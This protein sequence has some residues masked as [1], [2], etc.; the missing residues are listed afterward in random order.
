M[1]ELTREDVPTS[2]SHGPHRN[3]GAREYHW[4]PTLEQNYF[5]RTPFYHDHDGHK[6]HAHDG[7]GDA[8]YLSDHLRKLAS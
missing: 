1:D 8:Q 6:D 3:N 5:N 2:P 7:Y 4:H